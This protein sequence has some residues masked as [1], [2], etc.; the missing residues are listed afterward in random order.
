[1]V[2]ICRRLLIML[3]VM[4]AGMAAGMD[5]PVRPGSVIGL[6]Q[7]EG[8][9]DDLQFGGHV[10]CHFVEIMHIQ[11]SSSERS[12]EVSM[13]SACGIIKELEKLNMMLHFYTKLMCARCILCFDSLN[14]YPGSKMMLQ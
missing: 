5:V 7:L 10:K 13:S 6:P 11:S 12:V 3:E 2:V 1:M 8:Y 14:G 9:S 4:G